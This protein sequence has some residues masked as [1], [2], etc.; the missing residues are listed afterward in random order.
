MRIWTLWKIYRQ[1]TKL[2]KTIKETKMKK[3]WKSKTI[4][5]QL[6]TIATAI[7]GAVPLPADVTA[8]IVAAINVALRIATSEGVST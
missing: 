1:V 2:H 8:A 3:F 5:F 7:T 6:L 4:W